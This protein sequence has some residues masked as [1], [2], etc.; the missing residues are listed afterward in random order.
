MKLLDVRFNLPIPLGKIEGK[1]W[2]FIDDWSASILVD[3]LWENFYFLKGAITD[4]GSV[5]TKL[6]GIV[7]NGSSGLFALIFFL[8][9]DNCYVTKQR[10]RRWSDELLRAGLADDACKV[11]DSWDSSL[12]YY[13]LRI[14]SDAKKSWNEPCVSADK[15][16]HITMSPKPIY[17]LESQLHRLRDY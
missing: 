17:K 16:Q 1:D 5:P 10:N 8:F 9:H 15:F 4:L 6:Q 13:S 7:N 11:M 12:V 3:G 2:V 14:S